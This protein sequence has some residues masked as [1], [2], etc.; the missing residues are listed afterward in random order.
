M[1]ID[2]LLQANDPA[3]EMP[4]ADEAKRIR[5]VLLKGPR[6]RRRGLAVLVTVL[7]LLVSAAAIQRWRNEPKATSTSTLSV[8]R[9][10]TRVL[11]LTTA[12]G[13]HL[14][15]VFTNNNSM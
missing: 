1:N 8:Q 5:A 6:P 3:A 14:I 11:H 9:T 10:P 13:R 4:S 2:Q 15:W 7:S 12:G